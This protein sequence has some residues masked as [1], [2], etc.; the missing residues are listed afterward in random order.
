MSRDDMN[1]LCIAVVALG[2]I[3]LGILQLIDLFTR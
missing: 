1:A 3:V 2:V